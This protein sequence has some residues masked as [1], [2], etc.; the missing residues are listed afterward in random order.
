MPKGEAALRRYAPVARAAAWLR[1]AVVTGGALACLAATPTPSPRPV[2]GRSPG[3]RALLVLLMTK[4][5]E[6]H[7]ADPDRIDFVLK[8]GDF[9]V[10][11]VPGAPVNEKDTSSY[12]VQ[13]ASIGLV[14][15]YPF[16]LTPEQLGPEDVLI[17]QVFDSG[18]GHGQWSIR[19]GGAKGP[20]AGAAKGPIPF[21][22]RDND[23][24]YRDYL[25]RI[26]TALKL[27]SKGTR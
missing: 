26:L 20:A 7:E 24:I 11:N 14:D 16:A 4:P 23:E 22:N 13:R 19:D 9:K 6:K 5:L 21:F 1:A 12:V 27:S 25:E 15:K 17:V 18:T 8:T 3:L 2:P 10:P